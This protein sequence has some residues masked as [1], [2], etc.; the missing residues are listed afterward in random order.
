MSQGRHLLFHFCQ[1]VYDVVAKGKGRGMRRLAIVAVF[2]VLGI[3]GA[4][5]KKSGENEVV[6]R[7]GE[8]DYYRTNGNAAVERAVAKA[9]ATQMQFVAAI[10]NPK[11][12][13]HGLAVKKGFATPSGGLE[14]MWI[15]QPRW[16][17]KVFHGVVDNE[18][19]DTKLVKLGD[20]VTVTP[21]EL[22]DWMYIDGGNLVGGYT[23][24]AILAEQS[25]Q[26]RAKFEKENGVKVPAVDF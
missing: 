19:V 14:H 15:G 24:R 20:A 13:Y 4:L 26:E 3:I 16:D 2:V 7:E 8:P 11:P 22:S 21:S 17:G 9:R 10:Q 18:P 25:P 12:S 23:I 6:H 5:V 1:N